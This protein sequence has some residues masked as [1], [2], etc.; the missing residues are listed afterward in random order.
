MYR[1]TW[2][3]DKASLRHICHGPSGAAIENADAALDHLLL[4]LV[5]DAHLRG[6]PAANLMDR[7]RLPILQGAQAGRHEG[8]I[9]RDGHATSLLADGREVAGPLILPERSRG[10]VEVV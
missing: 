6:D 1:P 2:P 5:R 3:S 4:V 7:A 9:V 8:L 10:L